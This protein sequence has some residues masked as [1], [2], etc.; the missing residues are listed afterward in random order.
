MRLP[1][2]ALCL[3]AQAALAQESISFR[4]EREGKSYYAGRSS[5]RSI[6]RALRDYGSM[7]M[8][9]GYREVL[10]H[11]NQ[12]KLCAYELNQQLQ[13]K[14]QRLNPGSR[15]FVGVI[16][17]LRSQDEID[18]LVTKILL[19]AHTV[20]KTVPKLPKLAEELR[21]PADRK[22]I[23][24]LVDLIGSFE[25]RF[26]KDTCFDDAYKNLWSEIKKTDKQ[27]TDAHL[28]ALLVETTQ[29]GHL[30][31]ELYKELEK[32]R[33]NKVQTQGP[34]LKSYYQKIKSLRVQYPLRDTSE[35]S[36]FVTGA[37]EKQKLSRRQR[38][39]ENYTDLQ[40]M[41]MG[42][43][44]KKLRQRLESPRVEILVYDHETLR[45]TI[46]LEPME[47][48]RFAIKLLRKEMSQLALNT[49]FNGRSPDYL[50]L[51]TASYEIGI[52]PSSEL[53]EIAGLKEIWNP[54]KTLWDKAGVWIKSFSSVATIA[55]PPPYGFL[56]ALGIVVIEAT[57]GKKDQTN[58]DSTRLF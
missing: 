14:L 47:R 7:Q 3:M 25:S 49:Y 28:E 23:D 12:R 46:P 56:P 10:N 54:K 15:E 57:V 35:R 45:E 24:K 4:N 11:T 39:L 20:V 18:D 50:D 27:I 2:I 41:L 31:L 48:F 19:Q 17:F 42:N 26:L 34:G 30:S 9:D 8:L 16:Y 55:I 1:L 13:D 40:I 51:M 6:S 44:I 21:L 58:D 52:I 29:R 22:N 38:L 33:I 37:A 32:A 5:D 43:V 36:N 53:E